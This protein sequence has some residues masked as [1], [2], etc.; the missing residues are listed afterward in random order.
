MESLLVEEITIRNRLHQAVSAALLSVWLLSGAARGEP[1]APAA[2]PRLAYPIVDT[3]QEYC[4]DDSRLIRFPQAGQAFHG[5]DAQYAGL[6]PAYKDNGEGTVSDLNTGLM[7]QKTPNL[8]RKSTF[9]EAMA[10]AR[11]CRIGGYEDWRLPTIKEL[12]SLIDFRGYSMPTSARSVPYVNTD[13]FGFVHGDKLGG[14]VIDAQYWSGTEYVGRTMGGNATVFGVNFADGRIKGYPRDRGRRGAS[15]QFVRYVRGNPKYGLND[16]VDNG[17]DTVTDRATGLMWMRT[18][19]GKRLN[20]RQA[21]AYAEGFT[22]AGH[23]DWRLPNAKELQSIV[24]YTRAPDARKRARRAPAIDPVFR[25][26]E[27]ESWFWTSTSHLEHG[28]CTAAVYICFGQA[29]GTMH[30]RKMNVHGAGAQ[31]SDPKSGDPG[32]WPSGRGPQGDDIRIY[33]YVRCV[34]GGKATPQPRQAAIDASKF[35]YNLKAYLSPNR[36]SYGRAAPE[37]AASTGREEQGRQRGWEHFLRR[38]D[39]NRD[40]KV[41]RGEFDGPDE[42]FKRMDTNRDGYLS[43]REAR[44]L[45][46]RP[47]RR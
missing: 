20:W 9:P 7:W 31:R 22:H 2:Q 11:T 26:T 16:F 25:V 27:T 44:A 37:G 33:N 17:D 3:G 28:R 6:A 14:R 21:L 40:G 39:R 5:Q 32:R 24:D 38:L 47:Q 43:E 34:R 23:S 35:P 12:Y 41:S 36:R 15:R 45:P 46:P 10:G 42:H 29:G 1:A 18:D 19:S 30:G 13:V 8:K 4:Y